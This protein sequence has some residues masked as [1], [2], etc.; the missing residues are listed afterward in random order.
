MKHKSLLRRRREGL[1]LRLKIVIMATLANIVM[2]IMW[3]LVI[4]STFLHRNGG[5]VF[6][7]LQDV[8]N[9][10]HDFPLPYVDSYTDKVCILFKICISTS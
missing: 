10:L 8:V 1:V 3:M 5:L 7:H 4:F 6:A 9:A 2:D